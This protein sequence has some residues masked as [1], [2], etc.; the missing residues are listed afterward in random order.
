MS[1]QTSA[2][3]KLSLVSQDIADPPYPVTTKANG[4]KQEVDWDRLSQSR[5]WIY[6]DNEV[7]PWLLMLWLK[8][9]HNVPAGSWE[10]DDEYIARSLG[11]KLEFFIGHREQFMRGWVR[12]A[13][14]RLYHPFITAQVLEML[15][16][17]RA[18]ANRVKEHRHKNQVVAKTGSTEETQCNVLHS[19]TYAKEQEQEQEQD[20]STTVPIAER[21]TKTAKG[22]GSRLSLSALPDDWLSWAIQERP[23]LN[24][25]AAWQHFRDYWIAIPGQKGCKLDWLATWRN[26][27]RREQQNSGAPHGRNH[28]NDQLAD[29]NAEWRR[30][31][32]QAFNEVVGC[33][34]G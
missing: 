3:S 1:V 23:D 21:A 28:R 26:W 20:I 14:G 30:R 10:A 2:A 8:S 4:F 19:V 24:P 18:T 34:A 32:Q 16:R 9:W 17:R 25:D 29:I 31:G 11:C 22:R 12:H 6:A 27:V 13:D 15:G 5:T 33:F 7:R